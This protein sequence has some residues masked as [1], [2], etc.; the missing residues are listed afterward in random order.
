L[1]Y[2]R[3]NPLHGCRSQ[4]RSAWF[5]NRGSAEPPWNPAKPLWNPRDPRNL[6]EPLWNP[7][8]P[9]WNPRDPRKGSPL[10]TPLGIP[11]LGSLWN[12]AEFLWNPRVPRSPRYFYG[13]LKLRETIA[14]PQSPK[15][16]FGRKI[17]VHP[18]IRWIFNDIQLV[19]NVSSR[20]FSKHLL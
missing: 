8:E 4:W 6:A 9:L 12:P 17:K 16:S 3:L 18:K 13:A 2:T 10:G 5:S 14:A 11:P 7:A 15:V 1:C 20:S 19:L